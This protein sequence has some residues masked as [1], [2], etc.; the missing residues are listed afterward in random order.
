VDLGGL[1]EGIYVI[2]IKTNVQKDGVKVIKG[3]RRN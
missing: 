2:E 1:P 3:I